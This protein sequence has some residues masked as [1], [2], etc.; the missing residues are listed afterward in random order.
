MNYWWKNGESNFAY[1]W[2]INGGKFKIDKSGS[3]FLFI[4]IFISSN[5][6]VSF[7]LLLLFFIINTEVFLSLAVS[8]ELSDTFAA[9]EQL[10]NGR[11]DPIR[12]IMVPSQERALNIH[13]TLF[14]NTV[15]CK[16][17]CSG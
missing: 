4:R 5:L 14:G 10:E 8:R 16:F 15:L 3:L 12:V 13:C 11:Q 17:L 9:S 2:R 1:T 7:F 6:D